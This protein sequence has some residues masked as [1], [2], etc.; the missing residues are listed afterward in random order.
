M[1]SL[2]DRGPDH[3]STTSRAARADFEASLGERPAS[4]GEEDRRTLGEL[5]RFADRIETNWGRVGRRCDAAPRVLVHG[6]LLRK[7]ARVREDASGE[8]RMLA[9]DWETAGWGPPAAD[10]AGWPAHLV[11][12]P[13]A[14]AEAVDLYLAEVRKCWSDITRG[15]VARL[16]AVGTVFRLLAAVRWAGERLQSGSVDRAMGH[17]RPCAECFPAALAALDD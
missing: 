9:L 3:T 11:A 10:L 16:A 2:P 1:A 15:D 12:F 14:A 7:N 5:L 8:P 17:L 13:H 4:L 6:D